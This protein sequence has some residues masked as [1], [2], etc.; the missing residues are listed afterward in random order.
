[1]SSCV[2]A[3]VIT[4]GCSCVFV[5]MLFFV[6]FYLTVYLMREL[7]SHKCHFAIRPS[8]KT[9]KKHNTYKST[10]V[11]V[12]KYVVVRMPYV[13]VCMLVDDRGFPCVFVCALCTFL[14]V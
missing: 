8:V 1:M 7:N 14:F 3:S 13:I 5:Y 4:R 11:F 6:L 12:Y 9:Y 10:L 2:R